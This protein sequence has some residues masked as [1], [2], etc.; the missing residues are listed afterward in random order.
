PAGINPNY[1]PAKLWRLV[2]SPLFRSVR[3]DDRGEVLLVDQALFESEVLGAGQGPH[4]FQTKNFSS[5]IRQLNLYGFHKLVQ[6][7]AGGEE[8]SEDEIDVVNDFSGP[9]LQFHNPNFRRDRPD[10]L[11]HLIRLTSGNKAKLAA[12]QEVTSRPARQI[13]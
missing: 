9:L 6:E 5:F 7:L 13:Q 11:S 1:F 3:W 4:F 8:G 12:G 2:N 10:L